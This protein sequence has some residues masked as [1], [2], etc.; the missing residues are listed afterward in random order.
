MKAGELRAG[1]K[2]WMNLG[3]VG[4][5][6]TVSRI[7][8]DDDPDFNYVDFISIYIQFTAANG[9]NVEYLD[10]ITLH[11]GEDV[12]TYRDDAFLSVR[13]L[14]C[15]GFECLGNNCVILTR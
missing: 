12:D 11:R 7:L 15:L 8:P 10:C 5:M 3:S 1:D 6:A 4:I 13:K 2:V 14:N 9:S